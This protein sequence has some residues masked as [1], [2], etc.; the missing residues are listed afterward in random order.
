MGRRPAIFALI[1]SYRPRRLSVAVYHWPV[2]LVII[3]GPPGVGKLTVAKEL[4]QL[5]GYRLWH[6]HISLNAILPIF[7]WD[8]SFWRVLHGFRELIFREA[9][10]TG[11]NLIFTSA[12]GPDLRLE[13]YLQALDI[14]NVRI[15]FVQLSCDLDVLVQ[16]VQTPQREEWGK[17]VSP[18]TLLDLIHRFDVLSTIPGQASLSL[19]N[20]HLRH[21][22]RRA[23]LRS[24][25]YSNA[26]SE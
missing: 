4:Q 19:D 15:C 3:Y 13:T 6:N 2:N 26:R 10:A 14:G 5:T 21:G 7:E 16:R 22:K 1:S 11:T 9:A 23:L 20:T 8:D 17:T 24:I 18:E 12:L 25:S